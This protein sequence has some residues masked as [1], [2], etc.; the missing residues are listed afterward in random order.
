[1]ELWES[2][3]I[4]ETFHTSAALLWEQ[5]S[6]AEYKHVVPCLSVIPARPISDFNFA[7]ISKMYKFSPTTVVVKLPEGA[8][9]PN[10]PV[11][12]FWRFLQVRIKKTGKPLHGLRHGSKLALTCWSG[13]AQLR[14]QKRSIVK[15]SLHLTACIVNEPAK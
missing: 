2:L 7:S 1:M 9:G 10:L 11:G 14:Q 15:S 6:N 13:T 3:R 5:T 4:L 8:I 12:D